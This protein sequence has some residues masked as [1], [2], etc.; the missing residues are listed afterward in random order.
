VHFFLEK[1][2]LFLVVALKTCNINYSHPPNLPTQQKC[3]QKLDLFLLCLGVHLQLC[4]VNY[5]QVFFSALGVHAHPVQP[6]WLRV[7]CVMSCGQEIKWNTEDDHLEEFIPVTLK[8]KNIYSIY[9][10]FVSFL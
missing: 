3:P 1:V 2:D 5:A 9:L 7:C 10:H 6:P 4:S 8:Y